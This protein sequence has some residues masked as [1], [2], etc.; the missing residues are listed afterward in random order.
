MR[1]RLLAARADGAREK[2]L[3]AHELL[4]AELLRP[5]EL[6]D[7]VRGALGGAAEHALGDAEESWPH[8]EEA[9]G[10]VVKF[11]FRHDYRLYFGVGS[12][13]GLGFCVTQATASSRASS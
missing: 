6:G 8:H 3:P 7:A 4:E 5:A 12:M 1:T 2:E 9:G 13:I 10:R 11:A